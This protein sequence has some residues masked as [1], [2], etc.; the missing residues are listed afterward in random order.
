MLVRSTGA[1][2]WLKLSFLPKNRPFHHRPGLPVSSL[3]AAA[4]RVAGAAA[5]VVEAR[6]A[7]PDAALVWVPAVAPAWF[8][9]AAVAPDAAPQDEPGAGC[10]AASLAW[11]E[12]PAESLAGLAAAPGDSAHAAAVLSAMVAGSAG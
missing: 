1:S 10:V 12:V 7:L 2:C 5:A 4:A 9:A 6:D 8:A 11:A 3:E